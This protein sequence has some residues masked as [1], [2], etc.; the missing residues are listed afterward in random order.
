VFLTSRENGLVTI[1]SVATT[2]RAVHSIGNAPQVLRT[3]PACSK[4]CG[5]GFFK[6]PCSELHADFVFLELSDR[7]AVCSTQ[8]FVEDEPP[9]KDTI[10]LSTPE[11][12]ELSTDGTIVATRMRKE[13]LGRVWSLGVEA[14]EDGEAR[15]TSKPALGVWSE[16]EN[17]VVDLG[18]IY[19]SASD[20]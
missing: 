1:Y 17:M 4:R 20:F 6:H 5:Y 2:D 14:L 13:D 10:Q 7:G 12:E 18:D 11:E 19:K 9:P 16:R 3:L 8:V 15:E